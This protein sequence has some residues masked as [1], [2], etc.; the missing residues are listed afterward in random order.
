M[1]ECLIAHR[2]AESLVQNDKR[3]NKYVFYNF[4]GKFKIKILKTKQLTI[5]TFFIQIQT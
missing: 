5:K 2:K 4:T 1:M 3:Q